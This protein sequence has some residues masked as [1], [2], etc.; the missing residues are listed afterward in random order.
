MIVHLLRSQPFLNVC[1]FVATT[2]IWVTFAYYRIRRRPVRWLRLFTV[3]VPVGLLLAGILWLSIGRFI[4]DQ[5]ARLF[6]VPASQF[7]QLQI[8]PSPSR[9]LVSQPL[10]ISNET[11]IKDIIAAVRSANEY[12]PDHPGS[13][14]E[15]VIIFSDASG[16]SYVNVANTERQGS[17]LYCKTSEQG[18]IYDTLRSDTIG[19][20]LE[21]VAARNK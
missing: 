2:P 9:S 3:S 5:R 10:T 12:L 21:K 13:R 15:C 19:D 6:E 7:R 16:D 17:I 4:P 14:W 20:I 18:F 11:Q 8:V 1:V